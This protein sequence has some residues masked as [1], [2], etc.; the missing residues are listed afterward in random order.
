MGMTRIVC[1]EL[2][3]AVGDLEGNLALAASAVRAAAGADVVVLPE[4]VTSGYCFDSAD[5]A[6][7]V[8]IPAGHPAL[9]EWGS[10]GAIVI[11]GF[12]ELGADGVVYNSAA[13][14]DGGGV[15][16][17]YRKTHLWDREA[18]FFTPGS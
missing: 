12:A 9:R 10:H 1:A 15:R 7:S 5:E 2:A 17:V 4:L 6:R 8:A 3:P 13:L 16:A 14:V 18:L 11:G